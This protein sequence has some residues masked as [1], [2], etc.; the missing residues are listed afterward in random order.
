MPGYLGETLAVLSALSFALFNIVISRTSGSKGDK[1]VLFS[2][3]I[4]IAFSFTL[5]LVL[6]AGRLDLS[7]SRDTVIGLG[8]F[9]LAGIAAMMFGRTLVFDSIRRLGVTRA[10]AVKR[11][12]PFFSVLLAAFFLS[13]TVTRFD[14][15]GLLLIACAFGIL[16]N[17]SFRK[18]HTNTKQQPPIAYMIGATAAFAYA[19]AYIFRKSGLNYMDAPAFGTFI[20]ALSGFLGFTFLAIILKSYRPMFKTLFVNIDRNIMGA[21][22]LV[23]LGQILM[24]T[25]LAYEKVSTVVMISSLE[26]FFSIFLSTIVFRIEPPPGLLIMAA[27]ALAIIGVL[28]VAAA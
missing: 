4:T 10:S 26:V 24:F 16:I 28:M 18:G 12:N 20:S 15:M 23:S 8:S 1:G 25:A 3:L 6:E 9:A 2:V 22:V 17:D 11:L 5:F 14:L 13:E 19:I 7:A 27:V 21:A